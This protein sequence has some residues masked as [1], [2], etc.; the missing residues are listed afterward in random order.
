M[1]PTER[2]RALY[3][4]IRKRFSYACAGAEGAVVRLV[5]KAI[6]DAVREAA[7]DE[8]EPPFGRCFACG[9]PNNPDGSCFRFQ[10]C[11]SD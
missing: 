1:T 8:Q 6:R 7:T 2:A 5:A 3:P 10:C 4:E 11:N 9:F